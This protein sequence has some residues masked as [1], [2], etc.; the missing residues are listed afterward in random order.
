VN[1][2]NLLEYAQGIVKTVVL[3]NH[4][5]VKNRGSN[6]H[7]ELPENRRRTRVR[8]RREEALFDNHNG[9]SS[10]AQILLS[11]NC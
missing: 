4:R 9:D 6:W 7:S 5:V 8:M 1:H 3:C 2:Q 11:S 10:G